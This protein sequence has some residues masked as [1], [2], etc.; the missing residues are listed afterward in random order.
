MA[1]VIQNNELTSASV[2]SI[3]DV[4]IATDME[5]LDMSYNA[6][7]NQGLIKLCGCINKNKCKLRILE[8][9]E[10]AISAKGMVNFIEACK[11]NGSLTSLNFS[12][13]DLSAD[14][15]SNKLT[16]LLQSNYTIK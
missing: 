5:H 7:G 16:E 11:F 15:T 12:K 14:V 3:R 10:C 9:E 1:L 13:N 4:V 6:I 2:N 8:L